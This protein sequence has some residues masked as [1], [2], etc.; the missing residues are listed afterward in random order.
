MTIGSRFRAAGAALLVLSVASTCQAAGL[1]AQGGVTVNKTG[2]KSYIVES[3][4]TVA[5]FGLALWMVCKSSRR[6]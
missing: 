5:F 4:I 2:G 1:L 3:L 6:V